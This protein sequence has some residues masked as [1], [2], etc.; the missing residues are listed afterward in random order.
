MSGYCLDCGNTIC[1]CD[2]IKEAQENAIKNLY[3]KSWDELFMRQAYLV[4]RRS[5][6]PKTKIGAVL[7]KKGESDPSSSGYNGFPRGISDLEDLYLNRE[8]KY[9]LIVHGEANCIF[10]AARKG[11]STVGSII[12][13]QA[14]VCNECA[15]AIIQAGISEVIYHKQY[16]KLGHLTKWVES[17]KLGASM[18]EEVGIKTREF[19]GVLGFQTLL[20]GKLIDV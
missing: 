13:T 19:D 12:Y 2:E 14:P 9:Q 4:S 16:P 7:V 8:S 15:K 20:D 11:V 10:N 18:L 1:I 17:C 6:D 3:I 5:K